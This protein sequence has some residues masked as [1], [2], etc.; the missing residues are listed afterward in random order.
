MQT[1]RPP[2][3]FGGS[4]RRRHRVRR[5][6]G[7]QVPDLGRAAGAGR[8]EDRQ[9]TRGRRK[10]GRQLTFGIRLHFI[11][12]E[13]D[14]EA[15]DAADRLIS[16]LDDATI[17]EARQRFSKESD[18][19]G[20]QRMFA[21]HQGRR[22]KLEVSP[23]LWAGVGLVRAGA[24]TALVGSPATVAE[25]LREYQEVGID[26]VIGS[27]YPHLEEAYRVAELLFPALGIAQGAN[28]DGFLNEFGQKRVFAGGSHGGNLGPPRDAAGPRFGSAGC[29]RPRPSSYGRRS[30]RA[31]VIA[32]TVLP[33]PSAVA[34]AFWR[35]LLSGELLQNSWA[36]PGARLRASSSAA[37][38]GFGSASPT[39]CRDCRAT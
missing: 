7:G 30:R 35:L 32:P 26:T 31:G 12:R 34:A 1:P 25:R 6:A 23:N 16:R 15:W 14:D 37:A 21:L 36:R 4:S 29:C 24:G 5:R 8:R 13:T 9:G 22:D 2:L 33:A 3:F 19:V 28:G 10:R 17:E 39:A 20:Q 27:G 11:V 18:S 38:I